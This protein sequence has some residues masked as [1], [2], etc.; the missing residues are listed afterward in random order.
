MKSNFKTYHE[1]KLKGIWSDFSSYWVLE[2]KE[3]RSNLSP[4]ISPPQG[5]VLLLA[6]LSFLPLSLSS[7]FFPSLPL[8]FKLVTIYLNCWDQKGTLSRRIWR[9]KDNDL[10][11]LDLRRVDHNF[12]FFW[13]YTGLL[14]G[15]RTPVLIFTYRETIY[16]PLFRFNPLCDLLRSWARAS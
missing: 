11:K 5:F 10:E 4:A 7:S 2:Y 6:S 16:T 13:L 9:G 3:S 12:L 15:D 14:R 8:S 1:T